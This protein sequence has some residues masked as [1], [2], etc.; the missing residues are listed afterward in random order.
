MLIELLL[1][2]SHKYAYGLQWLRS[3]IRYRPSV[4][5]VMHKP[6]SFEGCEGLETMNLNFIFI[7]HFLFLGKC[8][9][10]IFQPSDIPSSVLS[11]LWYENYLK[12]KKK[13]LRVKFQ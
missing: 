3:Y 6:D 9:A 8:F 4:D 10:V 13:I 11:T 1:D 2:S 7:L 5:D 12:V